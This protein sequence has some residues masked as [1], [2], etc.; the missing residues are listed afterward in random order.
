MCVRGGNLCLSER[1]RFSP[2]PT[3]PTPDGRREAVIAC[4]RYLS[5][6]VPLS[7]GDSIL[8]P[9]QRGRFDSLPL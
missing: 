4:H 5:A 3:V 7:G 8:C 6:I 9:S 1:G 2:P